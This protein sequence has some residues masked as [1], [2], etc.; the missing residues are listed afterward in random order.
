MPITYDSTNESDFGLTIQIGN[1]EKS[2]I[3]VKI[4]DFSQIAE[5]GLHFK[6][7]DGQTVVLGDLT[8]FIKWLNEK[9][10]AKLPTEAGADWPKPI[11]D[12]LN[13][14]LTAKVTVTQLKIDQAP[15]DADKN[16]PPMDLEI[17]VIA[18][19]KTPIE[20]VT[21]LSVTSAAVAVKRTHRIKP[22]R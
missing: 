8:E 4:D 1:D 19:S 15:Q 18:K 14:V 3:T 7:P 17:S 2:T 11:K 22:T 13:G 16:Y 12:I 6:L 5:K 20:L 21:G 9:F 10:S